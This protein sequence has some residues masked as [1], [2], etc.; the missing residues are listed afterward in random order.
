MPPES[1]AL[2]A[3]LLLGIFG[4]TLSP[5]ALPASE[6]DAEV[7][8]LL[9]VSREAFDKRNWDAAL[10]PTTALVERFPNQQVFAERLARIYAGLDKAADEASAWELFLRVSP[11]PEDACPAVAEAYWRAGDP[12]KSLEASI[13]CRDF[14]PLSG[15]LHYY[16][17]RAYERAGR[18]ADAR[19]SYEAALAVEPPHVDTRV[20]LAGMLLREGKP[21]D[22]LDVIRVSVPVNP[23]NADVLLMAGIANQRLGQRAEA[24]K[25]LEKAAELSPAYADVHLV[26]GVLDFS[27]GHLAA[28]RRRFETVSRLDPARRDVDVW[29]TRTKGAS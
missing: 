1:R 28:A 2:L 16:L 18:A 9:A 12:D 23:D 21:R 27:E 26:L 11:T 15:E 3:V 8:K 5:R 10:G 13:R 14:D 24:R 20:A 25:A 6:G 17:G 22:A 19:A 7:E 29:L 4:W